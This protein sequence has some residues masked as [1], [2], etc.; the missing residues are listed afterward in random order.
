MRTLPLRDPAQRARDTPS[1]SRV[2]DGGQPVRV[3]VWKEHR[4]YSPSRPWARTSRDRRQPGCSRRS[5]S[6]HGAS[7]GCWTTIRRSRAASSRRCVLGGIA[8]LP[9]W[10]AKYGRAQG[11]HRAAVRQ[12]RR[13][14][15]R[16]RAVR[17]RRRGG[18]DRAAL[19]GPDQQTPGAH[20]DPQ[21]GLDDLLGRDPVVLDSAGLGEWLGNRVVMVT[22]AGGSI[23]AE[24]TRQIARTSRIPRASW[25]ARAFPK[26]RCTASAPISSARRSPA[27]AGGHVVGDVKHGVLVEDVLSARSRRSS[28]TRPRTSTMPL[29]ER[30]TRGRRCATT[31]MAPR[32]RAAAVAAKVE[33]SCSSRPTRRSTRPTSPGATKRLA[34]MACQCLQGA[35]TQFV[36]RAIRQRLRQR[37]SASSRDSASR[38]RPAAPVTVTHPEII[39]LLHVA[40]R[41]HASCCCRPGLQG[42]R[43]DPCSTWASRCASSTRARHDQ[44]L[45]RR[46]RAHRGRVHG[47]APGEK[48]YEEPLAIEEATSPP[49][50]KLHIAAGARRMPSRWAD[51]HVVRAIA[52]PTTPR[53][54]RGSRRGFRIRTRCGRRSS[55]SRRRARRGECASSRRE[56]IR[57]QVRVA[58]GK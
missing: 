5:R 44:A 8:E 7:W 46:S 47:V 53:C 22:G 1:C 54:G 39:A 48:L 12:P 6:R 11:D 28:S 41:G 29:M 35:G 52:P 38:S 26:P 33:A 40:V 20:H 51:G 19:R 32:A 2:P 14:P 18:A 34:E 24:L 10:C 27:A 42:R 25:A 31:R 50:P 56:R 15:A 13:A 58:P 45:G 21:R 43:G 49:H 30:P 23:G 3:P 55:H 4:L 57:G 36:A 9:R 16:R 17:E 37:G